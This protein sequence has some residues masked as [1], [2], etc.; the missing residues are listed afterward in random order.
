M[1]GNFRYIFLWMIDQRFMA[2]TITWHASCVFAGAGQANYWTVWCGDRQ[3]R[4]HHF[5]VTSLLWIILVCKRYALIND[6]RKSLR[7][8]D[9]EIPRQRSRRRNKSLHKG[10]G[11]AGNAF[12]LSNPLQERNHSANQRTSGRLTSSEAPNIFRRGISCQFAFSIALRFFERLSK[13]L[14]NSSKTLNGKT[15]A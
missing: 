5:D 11:N 7:V 10:E 1:K 3:R 2:S 14:P 15:L 6:D 13:K 4:L 8:S 12:N 9:S